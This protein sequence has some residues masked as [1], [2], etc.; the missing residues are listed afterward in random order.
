MLSHVAVLTALRI[1]RRKSRWQ[2]FKFEGKV[3]IE[4]QECGCSDN[5]LF[6]VIDLNRCSDKLFFWNVGR[7]GIVCEAMMG[8]SVRKKFPRLLW[9]FEV[10]DCKNWLIKLASYGQT[11][12]GLNVEIKWNRTRGDE[13][14]ILADHGLSLSHIPST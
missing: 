12:A 1:D 2:H 9:V 4:N 5:R 11:R 13:P 10:N 7:N 14:D 8:L 6:G 3:R